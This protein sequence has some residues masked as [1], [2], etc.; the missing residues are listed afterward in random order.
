MQLASFH[1]RFFGWYTHFLCTYRALLLW[2]AMTGATANS[3]PKSFWRRHSSIQVSCSFCWSWSIKVNSVLDSQSGDCD[4]LSYAPATSFDAWAL[5]FLFRMIAR[6]MLLTL[7]ID[8]G[9]Y[10]DQ[11]WMIINCLPLWTILWSQFLKLHRKEEMLR[12]CLQ[13]QSKESQ[14]RFIAMLF[15]GFL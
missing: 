9:W 2:V 1:V 13:L 12:K 5:E 7:P 4:L 8:W 10:L 6:H 15:Y 3:T 14:K 11:E